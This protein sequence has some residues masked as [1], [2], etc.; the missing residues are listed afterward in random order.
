M[1]KGIGYK[2]KKIRELKGLKQ[3]YLALELG[4]SQKHYCHLENGKADLRFTQ[5]QQIAAL[6]FAVTGFRR[7]GSASS[8]EHPSQIAGS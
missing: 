8:R 5:L 7:R 6:S 2:I 3:D 1:Q 4:V